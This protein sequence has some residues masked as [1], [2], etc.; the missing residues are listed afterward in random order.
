MGSDNRRDTADRFAS[1]CP[2]ILNVP[3]WMFPSQVAM[4]AVVGD[5][6]LVSRSMAVVGSIHLEPRL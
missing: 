4:M 1:I 3:G 2:C 5:V 6:F